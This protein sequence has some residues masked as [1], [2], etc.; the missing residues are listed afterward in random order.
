MAQTQAQAQRTQNILPYTRLRKEDQWI[1]DGDTFSQFF[2]LRRVANPELGKNQVA[3][4][5]AF[6][7]TTRY[8]IL[9]ID[10]IITRA[11]P[12]HMPIIKLKVG[13]ETA[14]P[15]FYR[16]VFGPELLAPHYSTALPLSGLLDTITQLIDLIH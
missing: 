15:L 2:Q 3:I 14:C 4:Y 10:V 5:T 13:S 11:F 7:Q 16:G 8:G 12:F 6:L 9:E 1:S